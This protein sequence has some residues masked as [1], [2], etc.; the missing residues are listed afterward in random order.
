MHTT[1]WLDHQA[2]LP[3]DGNFSDS[4]C[5]DVTGFGSHAVEKG[6]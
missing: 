3:W 4:L 5:K 6:W 1:I 2:M